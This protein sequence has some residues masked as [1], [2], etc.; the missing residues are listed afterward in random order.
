MPTKHPELSHSSCQEPDIRVSVKMLMYMP[1]GA[2]SGRGLPELA[3]LCGCYLICGC[4]VCA[5]PDTSA[6]RAL[7]VL[8]VPLWAGH[9]LA[10]DLRSQGVRGALHT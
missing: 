8:L 1:T 5:D 7:P 4:L 9:A 10:D 6:D 3:L 2:L